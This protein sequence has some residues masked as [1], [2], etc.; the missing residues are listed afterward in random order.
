[1][2]LL[3]FVRPRPHRALALF[4]AGQMG[5]LALILAPLARPFALGISSDR[6][7]MLGQIGR[8]AL[9]GSPYDHAQVDFSSLE[10]LFVLMTAAVTGGN[11]QNASKALAAMSFIALGLAAMGFYWPWRRGARNRESEA[12]TGFF[13]ALGFVSLSS[14][15]IS[16]LAAVP[17]PDSFLL[18]MGT[19]VFKPSHAIAFGTLGLVAGARLDSARD[20][21]RLGV[22]L[23]ILFWLF[24]VNWGFVVPSLVL[25]MAVGPWDTQK[26]KRTASAIALSAV[27]GAP[28]FVHLLGE[29]APGKAQAAQIWGD[30]MGGI[31]NDWRLW[32]PVFAPTLLGWVVALR[33]AFAMRAERPFLWSLLASP[34]WLAPSYLVG[35]R[36]GVAP[37]PDDALAFVQ[38]MVGAGAGMTLGRI[39]ARL[40]LTSFFPPGRAFAATAAIFLFLSPQALFDP[41]SEERYARS[42]K[43]ISP[44]ILAATEWIASNTPKD[45]VFVTGGDAALFIPALTGR[46]VHLLERMRP[47]VDLLDR[48]Q[49]EITL[50]TSVEA[51][52]IKG[53]LGRHRIDYVAITPGLA[54]AYA[55]DEPRKLGARPWFEPV[56][57]NSF[58]RILHVKDPSDY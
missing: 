26:M 54:L 25:A 14:F 34:L 31:L 36:I 18:W 41:A 21:Q 48:Q 55:M 47:P 33:P 49:T 32:G 57:V 39:A 23:S 22:V 17:N 19:F 6:S 51:R 7:I 56:F 35:L 50:L 42:L 13:M 52:E 8:V 11:P 44:A 4:V 10:P 53:V 2:A 24:I 16:S 58:L 12:W 3:V 38:L 1:M 30:T 45:A 40:D 15:T 46:R 29:Y 9:G 43:P 37:E 27:A 28:Y 20:A 5:L